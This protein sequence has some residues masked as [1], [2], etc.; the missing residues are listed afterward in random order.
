[1][2]KK[3]I[4]MLS[5]ILF[6]LIASISTGVSF[7][8]FSASV[9]GNDAVSNNV[10]TTGN[11]EITY[12]DG[13]TIGSNNNLIPGNSIEKSFSIKNTGD[14]D[15]YYSI[16]LND[17]VN[18][19]VT[20]EDLVCKLT[21]DDNSVI[22]DDTCPSLNTNV[23]SN[24]NIGVNEIHN[25]TLK[26]SF[27][28]VDRNQDDNK[29]KGFN[30]RVDLVEEE[31]KTKYIADQII[32]FEKVN[33]GDLMYDGVDTLGEFGT[34]DNNLRYVG[35]NPSNYIYFNCSTT[36]LDE[37]ND[38]TCEKW[39]IIGVFNNIEDENGKKESRVKIVSDSK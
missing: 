27:L 16:Y 37:M 19:F 22:F 34:D 10:I 36:N 15:A 6:L 3:Y 12:N 9:I 26:I 17:V 39:R 35:A 18:T 13:N 2:K 24:I 38:S 29:G 4:I 25:Y 1:M 30:A 20:K 8:F 33:T 31:N 7:A 28:F 14:V 11:M 5:I 21:R 23:A 32:D